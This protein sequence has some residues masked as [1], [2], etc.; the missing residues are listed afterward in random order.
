VGNFSEQ[1]WGVSDE[2]HQ[3]DVRAVTAIV[4]IVQ[5]RVHL[6]GLEPVRDGFG[7]SPQKPRTLVVPPEV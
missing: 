3:G 4:Q 7:G 1:V 5:A 6:N 2:R